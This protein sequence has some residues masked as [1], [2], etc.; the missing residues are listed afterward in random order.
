MTPGK[1][2]L[3]DRFET[4]WCLEGRSDDLPYA[5]ELSRNEHSN[6]LGETPCRSDKRAALACCADDLTGQRQDAKREIGRAPSH[7]TCRTV[8]R[9]RGRWNGENTDQHDERQ[10]DLET[11]TIRSFGR[12]VVHGLSFK[13]RQGFIPRSIRFRGDFSGFRTASS[14]S[15][16]SCNPRQVARE[17]SIRRNAERAIFPSG[18]SRPIV[19][20]SKINATAADSRIRGH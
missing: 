5:H 2:R 16:I 13:S 20:R 9:C 19:R 15:R 12:S 7:L 6:A 18:K 17:R 8:A 10:A 4:R 14:R 3:D 11:D 1:L